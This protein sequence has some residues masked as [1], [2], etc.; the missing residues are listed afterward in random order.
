MTTLL[1]L[2]QNALT[3]RRDAIQAYHDYIDM[4]PARQLPKFAAGT[5]TLRG[6]V[7]RA[8]VTLPKKQGLNIR[9]IAMLQDLCEKDWCEQGHTFGISYTLDGIT[10]RVCD[11]CQ[12]EEPIIQSWRA[13]IVEQEI[14]YDERS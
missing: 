13:E 6:V 9:Q 10:Y 4:N 14:Q 11:F 1:Q 8:P 5:F 12:H 2:Y 7:N 3:G